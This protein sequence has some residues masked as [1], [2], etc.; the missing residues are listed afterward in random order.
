MSIDTSIDEKAPDSP[1]R[2]RTLS[3][4]AKAGLRQ[5]NGLSEAGG[6]RVA[7]HVTPNTGPVSV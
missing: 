7:N 4:L 6:G 2:A 3:T 1:L 5:V